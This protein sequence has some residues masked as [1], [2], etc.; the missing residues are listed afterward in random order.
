MDVGRTA[1]HSH[2]SLARPIAIIALM[3]ERGF[4]MWW[5]GIR[6][7]QSI[8]RKGREQLH[9]A[10]FCFVACGYPSSLTP[11]SSASKMQRQKKWNPPSLAP[12]CDILMTAALRSWDISLPFLLLPL[13]KSFLNILNVVK[14]CTEC[15]AFLA[16]KSSSSR[17][18]VPPRQCSTR[19]STPWIF[20]YS[21]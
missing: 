6:P 18:L 10:H 3:M 1:T 9:L 15:W 16:F 7:L 4:S 17:H 20:C 5:R 11:R 2:R 13:S 8:S 12:I 19:C 14:I 21:R